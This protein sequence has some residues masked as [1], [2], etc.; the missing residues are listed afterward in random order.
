MERI[1]FARASPAIRGSNFPVPSISVFEPLTLQQRMLV[2]WHKIQIIYFCGGLKS[3]NYY[4]YPSIGHYETSKM[5][6]PDPAFC[7]TAFCY[8]FYQLPNFQE[9][10]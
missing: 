4:I 9:N 6:K 8:L 2:I 10:G 3:I 5:P 7:I 1:H